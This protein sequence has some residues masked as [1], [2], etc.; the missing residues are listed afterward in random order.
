MSEVQP[1]EKTKKGYKKAGPN[2]KRKQTSKLNVQK[3]R[4]VKN[5]QRKPDSDY[6]SESDM[7]SSSES[8]NEVIQ[9]KTE[10]GK[11]K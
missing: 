3:A 7:D 2:D 8:E 5:E 11:G 10:E 9:I 4:E 1:I 6:S